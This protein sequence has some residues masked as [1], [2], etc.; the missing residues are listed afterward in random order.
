MRSLCQNCG[1]PTIDLFTG[2]ACKLECDLKREPFPK[3]GVDDTLHY[4]LA[5][6]KIPNN[7][8]STTRA[9][10]VKNNTIVGGSVVG[11]VPV[12]TS[13]LATMRQYAPDI[14]TLETI[15][16]KYTVNCLI[17]SCTFRYTKAAVTSWRELCFGVLWLF[18]DAVYPLGT[19]REW[20]VTSHLVDLGV[21]VIRQGTLDPGRMDGWELEG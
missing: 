7:V 4:D 15:G 19:V 16:S 17:V 8:F 2:V 1:G 6:R 14:Q 11:F 12:G 9:S 18:N 21:S 13:I 10:A 3:N 5:M 20:D